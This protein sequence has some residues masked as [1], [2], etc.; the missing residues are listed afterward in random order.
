ME[1]NIVLI[2]WLS[3]TTKELDEIRVTQ[4]IE[5]EDIP[6]E[7]TKGARGYHDRLYFGGISI[8]YNG[9][10]DMGVWLEMSGQGCR[11]FESLGSGNYEYLFNFV[12]S[13]RGNIT[14]LDV[15]FDDHSGLLPLDDIVQDTLEQ[16]FV[17]KS[18]FWDVNI[19]SQ[20]KS[21]YHG[22]PKSDIRIRIYDKA[23][24][25]N[26]A[27]GTHWVRVELQLRDKRAFRFISLDGDI[28]FRFAGVVCNYL[29]YV[30]P[31]ETDSNRWRWPLTDYWGELLQG[32]TAITLYVKPGMDYNLDRCE[33]YVYRFAGNAIAA[34]I[35][36][37]G[38]VTF[39]DKLQ[40]RGTRP[41]PKY[42]N[43]V[44]LYKDVQI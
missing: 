22:S 11:T 3:I 19:S 44:N 37:Y 42:D 32:A 10:D 8:H 30:I 41:N 14:R 4:L 1:E 34:L 31:E 9:R 24:E 40:H 27:P 25:R 13:G 26:C 33:H 23:A 35:D 18:R 38:P 39:M 16:R 21:L 20:G 28:G 6:W 36:I 43:L 5:M 2:D 29:R 15:A 7:L 17:S 12:R